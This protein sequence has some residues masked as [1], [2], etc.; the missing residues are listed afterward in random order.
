[1]VAF[2]SNVFIYILEKNPEYFDMAKAALTG[3]MRSKS[4]ACVSVLAITEIV[5]GNGPT[6]DMSILS[7]PKIVVIELTKTVVAYKAGVLRYKHL[8]KTPDA[9]H[10]A[11]ALEA[12]AAEF[13]TNDQK[14]LKLDIGLKMLPLVTFA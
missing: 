4:G 6:T 1:M 14:L 8:I 9:I 5:S 7:H 10:L 11:S 12:G 2:D 13:I 3:A